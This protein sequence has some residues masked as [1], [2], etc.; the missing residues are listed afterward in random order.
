MDSSLK[1]FDK[2]LDNLYVKIGD[3]IVAA[4]EIIASGHAD[5]VFDQ[6]FT[7]N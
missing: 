2:V 6:E 1:D 7:V 5:F 4:D 3:A